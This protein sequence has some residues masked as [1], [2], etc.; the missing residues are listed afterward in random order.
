M[1]NIDH[2]KYGNRKNLKRKK[3]LLGMEMFIQ[4][5]ILCEEIPPDDDTLDEYLA[6]VV[7][8]AVFDSG[9]DELLRL[10]P[11]A[12]QLLD[13]IRSEHEMFHSI[14]MSF[15]PVRVMPESARIH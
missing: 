3:L 11:R 9:V 10:H 8:P 13:W 2:A 12:A 15:E 6:W 4:L 1:N 14:L 5:C 7:F